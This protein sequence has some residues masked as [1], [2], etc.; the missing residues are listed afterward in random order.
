M[1]APEL[2][3]KEIV[4]AMDDNHQAAAVAVV[5]VLAGLVQMEAI[6]MAAQA[7]QEHH[8]NQ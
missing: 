6:T 3:V 8:L 7:D 4:A 5:V 2:Q 1:V